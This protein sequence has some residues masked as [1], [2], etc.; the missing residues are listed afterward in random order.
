M[1]LAVPSNAS[2]SSFRK[3]PQNGTTLGGEKQ[4]GTALFPRCDVSYFRDK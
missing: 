1:M 4:S 2:L 3:T